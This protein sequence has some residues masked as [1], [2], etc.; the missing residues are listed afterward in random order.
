MSWDWLVIVAVG[1]ASLGAFHDPAGSHDKRVESRPDD[2][3]GAR[4]I[5][6]DAA[7]GRSAHTANTNLV[8]IRLVLNRINMGVWLILAV[9]ILYIGLE[10]GNSM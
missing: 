8:G 6:D 4:W 10:A 9:L 2:E 3:A 5:A 1:A 7:S